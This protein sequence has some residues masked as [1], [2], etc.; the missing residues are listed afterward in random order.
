LLQGHEFL[1]EDSVFV[2]PRGLRAVGLPNYLH[3]LEASLRLLPARLAQPVRS[4]PT[5]RRRSGAVKFEFDL[6]RRGLRLAR[7]PLPISCVAI[8]SAR[9]AR[10]KN[11]VRSLGKT[12]VRDYLRASQP[13]AANQSGWRS[14]SARSSAVTAVEM[15]R[16]AHPDETVAALLAVLRDSG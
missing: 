2:A 6:R 12:A 7:A 11:L 1:S 13:Y 15:S 5:I 10:G 16:G 3:V 4:S 9:Q 14:F 8:L